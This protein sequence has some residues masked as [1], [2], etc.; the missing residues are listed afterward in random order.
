MN[1]ANRAVLKDL[2]IRNY[3][4]PLGWPPYESPNPERQALMAKSVD[5]GM[6]SNARSVQAREYIK[7]TS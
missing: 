2:E 7:P 4:K 6:R 1:K 5:R 3:C